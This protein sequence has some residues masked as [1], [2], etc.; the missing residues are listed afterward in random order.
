MFPPAEIAK[1]EEAIFHEESKRKVLNGV[2]EDIL[3]L[4]PTKIIQKNLLEQILDLFFYEVS[5]HGKV[6]LFFTLL[7]ILDY[8]LGWVGRVFQVCNNRLRFWKYLITP[9]N[10]IFLLS[11]LPWMKLVKLGRIDHPDL[12]EV[13]KTYIKEDNKY[14]AVYM[15]NT[16]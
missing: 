1:H 13:Y 2:G 7:F 8:I 11:F 6:M 16:A 15:E 10:Q 4:C 9:F 14:V 12:A 5:H 3:N